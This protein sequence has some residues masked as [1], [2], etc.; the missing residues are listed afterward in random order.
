MDPSDE[1][2]K[3]YSPQSM[4]NNVTP[5]PS[6][7]ITY[8]T[9]LNSMNMYV[10]NGILR[11]GVDKQK[12]EGLVPNNSM[13][14]NMNNPNQKQEVKRVELKNNAPVE[15]SVKNSWIYNKYFKDYKG[16]QENKEDEIPLTKEQIREK[17]IKQYIEYVNAR[18]RAAQVKSTKML[19]SNNSVQ[20]IDIN[21][22]QNN[23]KLNRLFRF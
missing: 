22:S 9:I 21:T 2:K 12:L 4:L 20:Q 3:Y 6:P 10:E 7:K 16:V 18:K 5:K 19:F 17:K 13:Q 14:N 15:P 1:V 11:L 23:A 8:D